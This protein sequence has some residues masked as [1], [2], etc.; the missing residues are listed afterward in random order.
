MSISYKEARETLF[1]L[2]ALHQTNY[3]D[4]KMYTSLFVDCEELKK[5]LVAI[6]KSS[7][8]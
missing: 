6:L 4:E 8:L 1:W 2:K 5:I 3:L 7:K